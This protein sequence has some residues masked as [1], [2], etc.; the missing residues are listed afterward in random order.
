MYSKI[1]N[2]IID[3]F[4]PPK[5]SICKNIFIPDDNFRFICPT[6][7]K[8]ILNSINMSNRCKICSKTL[9]H[10]YCKFCNKNNVY[11]NIS[12]FE[13]TGYMQSL[14]YEMK[15]SSNKNLSKEVALLYEN[16]ILE[17]LEYFKSFD[18]V[19][20]VPMHKY[21]L[22]NRG[23]NQSEV[24]AKTIAKIIG[25][26]Y[27]PLLTRTKNTVPQSQLDFEKRRTN[28]Q[29]AFDINKHFKNIPLKNKKII[30]V[31]DIFTSGSTVL[32]CGKTF[33]NYDISSIISICI[34]VTK[35]F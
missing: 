17:N 11:K 31:D 26:P 12:I 35:I 28:L 8:V 13:Y 16:Y 32:N 20:S 34:T 15:Y 22:R 3:F 24:M 23:F 19:V 4:Y 1:L 25:I 18:Y 30:I 9:V 5:C 21:K 7:K 29:G 6:C 14:L 2:I 10:G 33:E 27:Y